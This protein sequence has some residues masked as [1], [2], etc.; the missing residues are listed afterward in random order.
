[1]IG[2]GGR[3]QTLELLLTKVT[4]RR[5]IKFISRISVSKS[6]RAVYVDLQYYSMRWL[7][8]MEF[9]IGGLAAVETRNEESLRWW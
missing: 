6:S 2:Q 5:A 9:T 7:P 4:G 1:M 8:P 3:G